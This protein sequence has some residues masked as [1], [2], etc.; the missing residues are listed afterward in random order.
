[1]ESKKDLFREMIDR[2]IE[3]DLSKLP[4]SVVEEINDL[5]K[6]HAQRDW[7]FY[8]LKFDE[9]ENHAKSYVI[10]GQMSESTYKKL[11]AK[12]YGMYD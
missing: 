10:N 3:I 6:Y 7:F 12:Y 8:D 5:E 2:S 4:K 11:L 9:M 1:M